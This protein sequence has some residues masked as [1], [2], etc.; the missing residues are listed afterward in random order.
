MA[1]DEVLSWVQDWLDATTAGDSEALASMYVDNAV[2]DDLIAVGNQRREGSEEIASYVVQL[3]EEGVELGH[4]GKPLE[5]GDYVVQPVT[6]SYQGK[7]LGQ[8]ALMFLVDQEN[9]ILHQ[10]VS[11]EFR[12]SE[13]EE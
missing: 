12:G 2:M 13:I 1:S 7:D 4:G 6:V 10:W 8:A 3:T 11:G 9:M 5:V